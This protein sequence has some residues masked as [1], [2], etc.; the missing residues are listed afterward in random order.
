MQNKNHHDFPQALKKFC[1]L[2]IQKIDLEAEKLIFID[3]QDYKSASKIRNQVKQIDIQF[4]D[5]VQS[6]R[7]DI[8]N[9][10]VNQFNYHDYHHKLAFLEQFKTTN[11]E[12][13]EIIQNDIKEFEKGR[14]FLLQN[15][16]FK[17]AAIITDEIQAL[18]IMAAAEICNFWN[19]KI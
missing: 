12:Y 8:N 2:T 15:H 6:V 4:K 10:N 16:D 19:I 7:N 14:K 9:S 3:N 1:E 13:S 18:K 5:I 11:T 17:N